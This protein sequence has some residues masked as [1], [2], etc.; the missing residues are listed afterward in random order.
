MRSTSASD[1]LRDA[2]DDFA[3][4]RFAAGIELA[5]NHPPNIIFKP[6]RQTM[7]F[8]RFTTG[9][10]FLGFHSCNLSTELY[11]KPCLMGHC[12]HDRRVAYCRLV[13]YIKIMIIDNYG[14]SDIDIQLFP[15]N[16]RGIISHMP[17]YLLQG[18]AMSLA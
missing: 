12:P 6:D 13:A 4:A 14:S 2:I 10:L 17:V 1:K 5:G 7:N 9:M 16:C 3:D 15:M 11:Q 18:I 8:Q